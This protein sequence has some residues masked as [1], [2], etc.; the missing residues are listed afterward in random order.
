MLIENFNSIRGGKRGVGTSDYGNTNRHL[1]YPK[2]TTL[3]T[4]SKKHI[5]I[6]HQPI[7]LLSIYLSTL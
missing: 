7:H 4:L 1:E 2:A 6:I 5:D 3:P